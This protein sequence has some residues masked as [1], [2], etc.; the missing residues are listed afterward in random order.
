LE[1]LAVGLGLQPNV[2]IRAIQVQ[3]VATNFMVKDGNY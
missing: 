1:P 2:Q 3:N